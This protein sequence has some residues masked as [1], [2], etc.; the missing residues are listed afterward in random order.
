MATVRA[1]RAASTAPH[2]RGSCELGGRAQRAGRLLQ[3]RSAW[4]LR[5][6][7]TPGH[8][9]RSSPQSAMEHDQGCAGDRRSRGD[10]PDARAHLA[11]HATR[12]AATGG[13]LLAVSITVGSG[14]SS[15]VSDAARPRRQRRLSQQPRRLTPGL[16]EPGGVPPRPPPAAEPAPPLER[17]CPLPP[18]R[19]ATPRARRRQAP[20]AHAGGRAQ[21][22]ERH[23]A[24]ARAHCGIRARRS[25][26][27]QGV[28]P[29]RQPSQARAARSS[30]TTRASRAAAGALL[31]Q[32]YGAARPHARLAST[33]AGPSQHP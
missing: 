7:T 21:E 27:T 18:C 17:V 5:G 16:L 11:P 8:T 33:M 3:R 24:R 9:C 1:R 20:H 32:G 2:P 22:R 31:A 6:A 23:S 14:L 19:R 28:S 15:R 26:G 25:R 10:G 13:V 4:P 12:A 30:G 29:T